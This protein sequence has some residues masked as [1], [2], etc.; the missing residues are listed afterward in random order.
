MPD[1][2]VVTDEKDIT[3]INQEAWKIMGCM[4]ISNDIN[5]IEDICCIDIDNGSILQPLEQLI[6]FLS[7]YDSRLKRLTRTNFI[8]ELMKLT[9]N[10]PLSLNLNLLSASGESKR[11]D[12]KPQRIFDVR[13]KSNMACDKPQLM[14]FFSDV[15]PEKELQRD[16]SLQYYS[17]MLLSSLSQELKVPTKAILNNLFNM[18]SGVSEEA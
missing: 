11:K 4:A 2:V 16:F 15:T 14:F 10:E 3:Y 1:G 6:A 17:Q 12:K 7:K 13:I 9:K 8:G 18:K 5:S